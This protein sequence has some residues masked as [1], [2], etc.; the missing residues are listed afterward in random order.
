MCSIVLAYFFSELAYLHRCSC[1][2][3][4]HITKTSN[5]SACAHPTGSGVALLSEDAFAKKS[6]FSR[7]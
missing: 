3:P 1:F 4:Y 6:T 2:E 5:L 7:H